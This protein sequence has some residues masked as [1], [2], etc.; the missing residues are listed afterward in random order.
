MR[1]PLILL[2]IIGKAAL[3]VSGV[4]GL[5]SILAEELPG[6]AESVYAE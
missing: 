3:H 4:G 2:K 6:L 1:T 5:W